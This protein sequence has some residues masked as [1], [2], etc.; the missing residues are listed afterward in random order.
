LEAKRVKKIVVNQITNSYLACPPA[1]VER[2]YTA[3]DVT[4]TLCKGYKPVSWLRILQR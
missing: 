2:S 1:V 3:A 4:H